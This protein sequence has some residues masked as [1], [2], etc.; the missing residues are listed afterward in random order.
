MFEAFL[1]SH[2][3]SDFITESVQ[4]EEHGR[5]LLVQFSEEGSGTLSSQV[6]DFIQ[7]SLEDSS[8]LVTGF[9]LSFSTGQHDIEHVDFVYVELE[10]VNFLVEGFFV[11]DDSVSVDQVFFDFMR[12]DSFNRVETVLFTDLLDQLGD[13]S[14]G[15][16]WLQ[17]SDGSLETFPTSLDQVG[18]LVSDFS[19]YDD[20]VA[21]L[22]HITIDM[23]S[24][25]NFD[26]V[27][28]L[29]DEGVVHH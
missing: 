1:D 20:G 17:E 8:P 25:V 13:L 3:G 5:V 12:K 2:L 14:V 9:G 7:S 6:V 10:G 19:S 23:H 16:S 29:Q 4:R 24:Q 11:Q 15:V 18:L 28:L 22:A 27:S 21:V 26:H